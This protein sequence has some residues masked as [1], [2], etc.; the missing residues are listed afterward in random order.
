MSSSQQITAAGN[1]VG[2]RGEGCSDNCTPEQAPKKLQMG[3]AVVLSL[4][5][6][7]DL[8]VCV[9]QPVCRHY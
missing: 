2:E 5:A 3:S 6:T 1:T 8:A 4:A 9:T 7:A